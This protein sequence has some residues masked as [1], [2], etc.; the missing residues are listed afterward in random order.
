[1]KILILGA[2]GFIGAHLVK[3]LLEE[4]HQVTGVDMWDDKIQEFLS[5][6]NL[7]FINQDI[8]EPWQMNDYIAGSDLVIDLIAYAN[9]GL[10]VKLPLEVFH[11]NFTENLKI[12]E[13]CVRYS[14]RLIQFSSCEVY[15]K[16]IVSFARDDLKDPDDPKFATF[17]E[18]SS[19][20]ILG[21]VDKHRWIYASAKQLLERVL[22]A[23]GLEKGFNY[24][25]IR[26]FNFIG[27]K[28]DYLL[29][30]TDGI[31]RVFSY[32]MDALI[33][34]TPMKLVDGGEQQRSYT[35]IDD[36]ID[37]I[38]RIVENPGEVCNQQIF[39]V[40]SPYNEVSMRQ[41]A[42]TMRDIYAARYQDVNKPISDIIEVPGEEFYGP[43]Y[44]DSD[45]RIPDITKA[46]TLLNWE[47]K[48]KFREMLEIT[49][50]YYMTDYM[51]L[52]KEL[53]EKGDFKHDIINKAHQVVPHSA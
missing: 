33:H 8:R 7:K 24:S 1:M 23:Y 27:P 16:T 47:P 35:Y 9:P 45:R 31:P 19:P 21:A 32:F 26:P 28:I 39:N 51:K 22:H 42:E 25:I 41:L 3:K 11:L 43:G 52:V 17:S 34:H 44:E 37:C 12:A 18:E 15:G 20:Y 4:A 6:D 46:R 13:S 53:R 30:E 48:W 2:G 49:M 40:G 38:Y 10:Y 50:D 5:N 14:K 36:A 29:D